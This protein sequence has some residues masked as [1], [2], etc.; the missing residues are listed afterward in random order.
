MR[1]GMLALLFTLGLFVIPTYSQTTKEHLPAAEF[2][3]RLADT[4]YDVAE[5]KPFTIVTPKGERVEVVLRRKMVLEFSDHGATFN[6]DSAMKVEITKE[7]GMVTILLSSTASP[8]AFIQV[9]SA[10]VTPDEVRDSLLQ[11]LREEFKNRGAE[12]L[13]SSGRTVK[14]QFRGVERDGQSLEFLLGGE[15][16]RTEVFAFKKGNTVISVMLQHMTTEAELAKK[17]FSVI[18]SSLH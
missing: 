9:H 4:K 18:T 16:T 7:L 17:Y 14:Q 12:F 2:E 5:G 1:H 3:L 6:Y 10:A 11:S 15:R 13:E 8:M